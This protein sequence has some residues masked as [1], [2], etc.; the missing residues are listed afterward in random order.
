M[1]FSLQRSFDYFL[2]GVLGLLPV[3]IVVQV[4]LYV[5]RFL[6]DFV[7]NIYG[8]YEDKPLLPVLLFA[9]SVA[10]LVYFG[11]L[12]KQDK[13]HLLYYL[14]KLLDRI[15]VLGTLYRVTKKI[16]SLFRGDEDTRLRDVVYVEYPREGI[17]VPA[18]VTNRT[19]DRYV[20]YVPTSPNPTSGFTVILHESRVIPSSMTIEEA[21][22][23]VISLGVDMPKP[24]EAA[25]LDRPSRTP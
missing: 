15:P 18:F 2:I 23:F 4:V 12:L 25:T 11:Y 9:G 1:K 13:A 16:L 19:G 5:E 3:L 20:V 7:V 8:R 21:S 14:E 6:R 24:E 10:F 17:W 22:S